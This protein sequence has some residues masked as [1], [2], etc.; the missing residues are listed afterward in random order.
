MDANRDDPPRPTP[1]CCACIVHGGRLLLI[2]RGKEPNQGFWSFP[3]GRIELEDTIFETAVREVREETGVEIE[4]LEL[5]Q[6]YD[7]I[8]RDEADCVR[9]HYVVNYVRARCLSGV[10]RAA[11]DAAAVRW[12]TES[13]LPALTMHPFVRETAARL[14]TEADQRVS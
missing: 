8:V 5:F 4:P 3:G 2:Q 11:S 6:V 13:D 14:L 1:T 9:F 10:P 7:W 12:V